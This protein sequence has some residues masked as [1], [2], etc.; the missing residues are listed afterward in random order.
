MS[1]K[2]QR[3]GA[4]RGPGR[5]KKSDKDPD[6]RAKLL[7]LAEQMF[8]ERG[9]DGVSLRD[10]A[11]EAGLTPAMIHYYFKNKDGLYAAMLDDVTGRL[12]EQVET[13]AA[14]GANEDPFK[15][16]MDIASKTVLAEPWA[17]SLIMRD[18]L[19][20]PGPLRDRFIENYASKV[21]ALMADVI[22]EGKK[23]GEI[24]SDLDEGFTAI[25][26]L[27]LTAFPFIA[28]GVAESVLGLDYKEQMRSDYVEHAAQLLHHG[29]NGPKANK[30]K[31]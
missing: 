20:Q 10:L 4:Q 27:G 1:K 22:I 11:D 7:K 17:V 6:L 5:P 28:R 9:F 29:I 14:I 21:L 3:A 15:S 25:S 19:L 31:Q 30:R 13:A 16:F 2:K 18:V 23:K 12:L 24:R 26:L 8:A